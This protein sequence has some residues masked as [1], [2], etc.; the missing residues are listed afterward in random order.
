[1]SSSLLLGIISFYY[2]LFLSMIRY[3]KACSELLEHDVVQLLSSCT[4]ISGTI[5][6]HGHMIKIGLDV[7]PFPLSKLLASLAIAN[8]DYAAKIFNEVDNPNLFMFNTLLRGYS[9]NE[10]PNHALHL[11]NKLRAQGISLDQFSFICAL[12]A[13]ARGVAVGTGW[14][15]HGV[16]VQTGFDLFINVRNALLS[17]YCACRRI[18]HAQLLFDMFPQRDVVSWNTLM[19]GYLKVWQPVGVVNLFRKIHS[20]GFDVSTTT[21]LSVLSACGDLRN[22][23]VGEA[24]HGYC[25]KRNFCSGLNV[26]TALIAMYWRNGYMGL[27][28]KL[29]DEVLEK[30]D[31][32]KWNCMIEGYAVNGEVEES[33]LLFRQMKAEGVTPNSITLAGLLRACA[34]SGDLAVGESIHNYIAEEGLNVDEILG[35]AL[36]DMYSKCGF[37]EKAVDV[38][39]EMQSKDVRCWT[40]MI[41]GYGVNGQSA[42]ALEAFEK[43]EAVGVMPN[44]V[45]FLAMLNACSHGGMV[46]EG[47]RCFQKMGRVYGF[48]PGIEHYGC[49]IDM[50]G[51]AGLLEEAYEIIRSVPIERDSTAWR[52]LLAACRLHGNVELGEIAIRKLVELNDEQPTDTILLSSSYATQGRWDDIAR[53]R[54]GV[55]M[56][57]EVAWS[58]IDQDDF[59][60]MET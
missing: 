14:A 16:L 60:I 50:L 30:N 6:V 18:Q 47:K 48:L 3:R 27:A 52:A 40:A 45:T 15:I 49:M 35:T 26:V 28:R 4:K 58:M 31:V 13:C 39:E 59:V 17:Y 19:G 33:L 54:E 5:Q 53:M 22:L 1:M 24:L 44:E 41:A 12:K 29:F 7:A 42:K 43:M 25:I 37:L 36:L 57:K 11:F 9:I 51:R 34:S 2:I 10:K 55:V 20:G 8:I 21:I 46:T 38:F 56:R 23:S 32:V